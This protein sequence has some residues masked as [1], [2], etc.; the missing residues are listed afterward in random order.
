MN[1]DSRLEKRQKP[2]RDQAADRDAADSPKLEQEQEQTFRQRIL[3]TYFVRFHMSLILASVV[4]SGVLASRLLLF[5][6]IDAMA[7]RYPLAVLIS[8]GVFLSLVR[9]WIYW[10]TSA[11]LALDLSLL[12]GPGSGGSSGWGSSSSGSG[13]GSGGGVKF[14]GGSSGGG[15]STD[16][17]GGGASSGGASPMP[18][19]IVPGNSTV[20]GSMPGANQAAFLN[21]STTSVKTSSGSKGST[22]SS[23]SS[24]SGK[25]GSWFSDLG[26]IDGDDW[27]I[28]LLLALLV[29][30]ILG[31]GGYLIYAAPHVLPEAAWQ[32]ALAGGLHRMTKQKPDW[33]SCVLR[34]SVIPF[35]LVL[36][37]ATILGWQA[38]KHCPG[39]S[40]LLE[41]LN[42][43]AD[44]KAS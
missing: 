30:A 26:G 22:G 38:Q 7:L 10:V 27:W 34:S 5:L 12:H 18:M 20:A 14:G 37:M 39:A 8:Y 17:W 32:A 42:C 6:G 31:G 19:P 35:A 1:S 24:S 23:S 44:V 16:S 13:G 21:S 2:F 28:L 40:R 3:K 29:L 33:L 36:V 9:I 43:P 11:K 4:V 25:S 41:V 15:G